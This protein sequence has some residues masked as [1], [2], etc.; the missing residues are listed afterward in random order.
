M[1]D[2]DVSRLNDALDTVEAADADALTRTRSLKERFEAGIREYRD[3]ATGRDDFGSYVEF[4][5]IAAAVE[6]A[7]DGDEPVYGADVLERAAA[8][9]D[10]RTIRPKHFDRAEEDLQELDTAVEAL[11][12]AEEVRGD[13]ESLRH[14]LER[15]RNQLKNEIESKIEEIERAE[16]FADVDYSDLVEVLEGYN[17]SVQQDF[18]SYRSDASASDV[19]RLGARAGEHPFVPDQPVSLDD[20]DRLEDV[21]GDRSVEE[22]MEMM[23]HSKSKLEHYVDSAVEFRRAVPKSYLET[24]DGDAFTVS[25][26]DPADVVRFE[27]PELLKEVSK[28]AGE[29]T[30]EQL[31]RL[32]R[33]AIKDDYERMRKAYLEAGDVDVENLRRRKHEL[34]EEL[35]DVERRLEEVEGVLERAE[36]VLDS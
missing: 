26:E 9:F 12:T 21:A 10:R 16:R 22:V 5:S 36:D 30:V 11:D 31:R 7:V 33:L 8:R 32:R 1:T 4:R 6:D 34:E 2:E 23:G 35:K 24:F 17:E 18:R 3:R 14:R 27:V 25:W 20:A 28:F 29:D 15:R 19:V 13:V